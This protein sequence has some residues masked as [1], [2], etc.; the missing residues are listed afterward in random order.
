MIYFSA[1]Y[2]RLLIPG[3]LD[4]ILILAEST[5]TLCPCVQVPYLMC[6]LMKS[7]L[8]L[9]LWS[10]FPGQRLYA[11]LIRF[12]WTAGMVN[13]LDSHSSCSLTGCTDL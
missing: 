9:C 6:L 10:F 1:L 12:S 13:C 3:G 11:V 5:C 4:V 7:R 2:L 8:L